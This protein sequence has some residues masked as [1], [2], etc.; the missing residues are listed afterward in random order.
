MPDC[1]RLTPEVVPALAW[2]PST[3]AYRLVAQG[4][5]LPTWHPLVSG[6]PGSVHEAGVSVR[7][8]VS[9]PEESFT[10]QELMDRVVD[11][12]GE[13]VPSSGR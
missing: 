5:D 4:E 11:W 8:R 13:T 6:D 9:G 7:D 12:P 1:V 3:C 2:L 10:L